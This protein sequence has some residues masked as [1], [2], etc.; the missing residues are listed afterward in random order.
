LPPHA[1]GALLA[2]AAPAQAQLLAEWPTSS[3]AN[4]S[5]AFNA[6]ELPGLPAGSGFVAPR[7][8]GCRFSAA[9][10]SSQ[11]WPGRAPDGAVLLR[12][13][14]GGAR[15]PAGWQTPTATLV[16]AALDFLAGFQRGR[17]PQPLW[18]R[19]FRWPDGFA[20]PNLGHASR[21]Q[22][23]ARAAV[24]GLFL[25]GGYFAGV[26]IPDCLARAGEVAEASLEYL[27]R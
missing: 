20:Q 11:K 23:L 21:H 15:D 18:H 6:G 13:Y 5:L 10:W 24:D 1:A 2:Q 12:F 27:H 25:A 8:S 9:T 7:G 16:E 26:G 17:R 19:V 14:A 4:L 22:A 3:V